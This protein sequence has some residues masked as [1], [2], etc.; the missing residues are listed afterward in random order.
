MTDVVGNLP[1]DVLPDDVARAIVRLELALER[2]TDYR[3]ARV[4]FR[5]NDNKVQPRLDFIVGAE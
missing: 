5:L 1:F 2:E 4:T 3:E